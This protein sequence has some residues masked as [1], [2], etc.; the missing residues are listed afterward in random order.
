VDVAAYGW[1]ERWERTLTGRGGGTRPARVLR[2]DRGECD[3][4]SA[5]GVE[6]VA[7]DS[8]RAQG[9]L[10]P[11]AGDWVVLDGATVGAVL[12]RRTVL[13][14]RDPAKAELAQVLVAN[15]DLVGVVCGRD[16]PFRIGRVE[17]FLVVA[18]DGGAEGVVIATKA[19]HEP[20]DD[21]WSDAAAE[22]AGT[23]LVMT[24]AR[25]GAGIAE[26]RRL[27]APHRTMALL[28]ESGAG[29]SSLV[30]ALVGEER[31]EIGAVRVGDRKGRHTT[32]ARELVLVPTGGTVIDT[33]GVR[34]V[35]LWDSRDGIEQ[36]FADIAELAAGCRFADC[37]HGEEPGCE[38]RGAVA[39][40]RLDAA[41]AQRYLALHAELDV[42]DQRRAE[43]S[44]AVR[45]R[46]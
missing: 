35:G 21:S 45:R 12:P 37:A 11:A 44:W 13:V 32:R 4:V 38:V 24:S 23:R 5:S 18:E 1:D 30:N 43:Q 2:V 7:S 42:Q 3:V 29:K 33:P 41:R 9:E 15:V 20:A 36:V 27:L 26:L 22:L 40:G 10:A 25:T 39:A 46:R 34:S 6:R 31:L 14:R 17:R 16:R 28:G 8:V 19:D